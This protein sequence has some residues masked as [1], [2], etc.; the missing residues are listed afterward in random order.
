[1]ESEHIHSFTRGIMYESHELSNSFLL[2]KA[3]LVGNAA[4]W[5]GG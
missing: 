5:L 2:L 3:L 4:V 1:M